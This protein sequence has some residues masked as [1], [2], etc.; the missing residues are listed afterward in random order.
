MEKKNGAVSFCNLC[1]ATVKIETIVY[2]N[3][4]VEMVLIIMLFCVI[5][6]YEALGK[7]RKKTVVV[8]REKIKREKNKIKLN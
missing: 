1:A 2:Y 3:S 4:W 5:K 7:R 8:K 6:L